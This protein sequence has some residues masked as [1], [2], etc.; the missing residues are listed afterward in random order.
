MKSGKAAG[1]D[2]LPI[3]IYKRFFKK[4]LTPFMEMKV[5]VYHQDFLPAL[6]RGALITLLPTPG[7]TNT[8]C[9][10]MQPISLLNSDTKILSYG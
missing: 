7:K 8:K 10:N 5:E 9:E 6:M 2:G 1:P 3:E 4:L